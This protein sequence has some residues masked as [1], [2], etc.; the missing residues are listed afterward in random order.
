MSDNRQNE[1]LEALRLFVQPGAVAELRIMDAETKGY[2]QN[3]S[4]TFDSL[5]AMAAE[6]LKWNGHAPAIYFTLN[7][8]NPLIVAR[9]RNRMAKAKIT[10]SDSDIIR[11]R[12]FPIDADAVK[13][14]GVSSPD[15]L[16]ASALAVANDIKEWLS[17]EGWPAP[18]EADSGNG[19]HLCYK[20]DLPNTKEVTDALAAAMKVISQRF[21][22]NQVS[23]DEKVFNASR[24]WKLY[25]TIAA[26]G[27][28][29][30]SQ[31]HRKAKI[32][33]VPSKLIIVS[34]EQIQAIAAKL[35]RPAQSTIPANQGIDPEERCRKWG[36]SI[37]KVQGWK[38]GTKYV[39]RPCPF[40]QQHEEG[41]I[42][43]H[44]SGAVSFCCP[45]NSCKDNKWD[46]LR[47]MFEQ[48]PEK[49]IDIRPPEPQRQTPIQPKFSAI[50]D[51]IN[52]EK[53]ISE[54]AKDI[55][56]QMNGERVTL[57]MPWSMLSERSNALRPGSVVVLAGPIKTGKSYLAMNLISGLH[58]QGVTWKYLP[59]EDDRK[60]WMWRMMAIIRG[61]YVM[62]EDSQESAM[63][64][65]QA[66]DEHRGLIDSYLINVS[67]NPRIGVKNAAGETIVPEVNYREVVAWAK[68]HVS[69]ARILVID[70]FAQI[71]FD[72]R[73]QHR[74]EADMI[75]SLLAIVAGQDSTIVLI[76]HVGKRGGEKAL[77]PMTADDVQGSVNLTRLA[78]TTILIDGHEDRESMIH[79][80]GGSFLAS[81]NR[82]IT[83]AA[84]RNGS[85][86]RQRFAFRAEPGR[87]HFSEIGV[88]DI[89]A[90]IRRKKK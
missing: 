31:P 30:A 19:G 77:S 58:S 1:I 7:E 76:A 17:G 13:P 37:H 78:H 89:Q 60:A 69:K 66:L 11:R 26:K 46:E 16:H 86:T 72:A 50:D 24:I 38:D 55:E 39:V 82:T 80:T 84:A 54:M 47:A 29:T 2:R 67:E 74:E 12:W 32:L 88:I 83:I 45:H 35:N 71:D 21:S 70:P 34:L 48:K 25:G 63:V 85:G 51:R 75:R 52:P 10:T 6:A 40:N 8:C 49:R 56:S 81:H 3:L 68:K 44:P 27:D 15:G 28:N 9:S 59:L 14:A 73:N 18:I 20:I 36:L 64:R 22:T 33:D 79:R 62:T 43:K 4:G 42:I 90:T 87:P 61:D 41:V 23:V 53:D 57:Q 5:E 65:A